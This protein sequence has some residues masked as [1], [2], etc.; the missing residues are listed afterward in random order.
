MSLLSA[1]GMIPTY[2]IILA[3]LIGVGLVAAHPSR[4]RWRTLALSGLG[5]M[6][7]SRVLG[8]AIPLVIYANGGFE[9]THVIVTVTSLAGVLLDLVAIAFIV[10]AILSGRARPDPGSVPPT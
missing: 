3:W 4:D 8:F 5:V 10:A 7:I 9:T 6:G 1:L 2:L